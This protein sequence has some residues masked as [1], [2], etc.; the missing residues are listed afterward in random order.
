MKREDFSDLAVFLAVAEEGTFTRAAIRL[1]VSQSAVSHT[2][3]R[4]EASL[5]F[6]LLNRSTR[7]VSTTESGEKLLAILR[8]GIGQIDARIEELRLVKDRPRGLI[9]ITTAPDVARRL[10]WPVITGLIRDYPEIR[11]E[12][13]T[14]SRVV[15]LAESGFDAA[16]R[17]AETVGPDLIAVP[18]GPMLRMAAVASPAY[19]AARGE[20]LCPADLAG[21]D[22]ITMRFGADTAPYDW[23]FERDGQ[24]SVRKV[25][26]PLIFNDGDLCMAAAREGY[27]IAY[28]LLSEV[29]ADLDSGR[30]RRVLTEWCPP[31]EGY[32]LC[33]SSRRQMTSALRLLVDRM[34]YRG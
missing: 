4:L 31:F 24:E 20:P 33:Y 11:V 23:E 5:G 19:L 32:K 22:C 2:I 34:R 25:K 13:N 12:V 16:I 30:L 26:G 28:L 8:P 7:N 3:R 27:G 10:L 29:Q 18:V 1:G 14:N 15:D 9:R 17:L 6:R 21:H